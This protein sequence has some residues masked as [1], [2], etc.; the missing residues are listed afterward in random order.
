MS[1]SFGENITPLMYDCSSESRLSNGGDG[2]GGGSQDV[3]DP[4]AHGPSLIF[5]SGIGR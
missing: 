1:Q 5:I 3:E 2:G 4:F